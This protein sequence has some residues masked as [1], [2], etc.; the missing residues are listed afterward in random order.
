[1]ARVR[2]S[3]LFL[4]ATHGLMLTEALKSRLTNSLCALLLLEL[5]IARSAIHHALFATTLSSSSR[6][7]NTFSR[8]YP[9]FFVVFCSSSL[10]D[11]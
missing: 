10:D 7:P 9:L 1:M 2:S 4:S 3:G 6:R 5:I 8:P 11:L